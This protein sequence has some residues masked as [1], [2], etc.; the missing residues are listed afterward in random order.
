MG[1]AP[2]GRAALP[3]NSGITI[4]G[5]LYGTIDPKAISPKKQSDPPKTSW[6]K[7]DY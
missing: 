1:W 6:P 2:C 5:V 4:Q 7:E 3:I